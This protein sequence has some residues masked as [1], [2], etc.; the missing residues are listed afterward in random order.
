[1]SATV[2][3]GLVFAS[4]TSLTAVIALSASRSATRL[5]GSSCA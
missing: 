2:S 5:V 3:L 1:M 4:V